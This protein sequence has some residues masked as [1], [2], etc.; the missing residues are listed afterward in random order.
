MLL[1]NQESVFKRAANTMIKSQIALCLYYKLAGI[2]IW[3]H[4]I[5]K[6]ELHFPRF[7]HHICSSVADCFC[8]LQLQ[9][10]PLTTHKQ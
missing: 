2:S 5:E 1:A 3:V 7:K 6:T 10:F 9:S 8:R 4:I